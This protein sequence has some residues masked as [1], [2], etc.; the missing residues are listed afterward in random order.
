MKGMIFIKSV[1]ASSTEI[2]SQSLSLIREFQEYPR[3]QINF[4]LKSNLY[5]E[6]YNTFNFSSSCLEGQRP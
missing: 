2:A 6:I 1:K 4:A 3:Y 5:Y